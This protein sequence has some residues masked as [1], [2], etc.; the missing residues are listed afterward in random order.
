MVATTLC[1]L[2]IAIDPSD[3][4][5]GEK[6]YQQVRVITELAR[7]FFPK[8]RVNVCATV[9]DTD[10]LALSARS[11][12][13]SP[14]SR[15]RAAGIFK[16]LAGAQELVAAGERDS[17]RLCAAMIG[18]LDRHGLRPDYV[19][20]VDAQTLAPLVVVDRDARALI[21]AFL[22]GLRLTDNIGLSLQ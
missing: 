7:D 14:D 16:A 18:E 21:A 8:L 17:A 19:A 20:V 6:D 1:K 3:I 22:D 4:Y 5:L 10:G 15:K 13:L 11:I 9:R 2:L 12:E